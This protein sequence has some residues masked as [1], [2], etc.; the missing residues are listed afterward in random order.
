[1]LLKNQAKS[2]LEIV[3]GM[4]E[5]FVRDLSYARSRSAQTGQ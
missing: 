4:H 1:M 3:M 5:M 2:A